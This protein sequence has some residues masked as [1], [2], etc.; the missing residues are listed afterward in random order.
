MS[1]SLGNFVTMGDVLASNDPEAFRYFLLGTH[2]RGQVEFE[3]EKK[4]E[5]AGRLPAASTRRSGA[6]STST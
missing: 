2:Y 5:R 1:K 4:R 3:V 6:S